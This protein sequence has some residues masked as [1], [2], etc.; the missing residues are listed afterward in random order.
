MVFDAKGDD[1]TRN[2]LVHWLR[3]FNDS[4]EILLVVDQTIWRILTKDFQVTFK[5][6]E[7]IKSPPSSESKLPVSVGIA[8]MFKKTYYR[9]MLRVRTEVRLPAGISI[10]HFVVMG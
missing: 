8:K 3:D 1:L 10:V 4:L 5:W 9:N 6:I 7:I 2:T